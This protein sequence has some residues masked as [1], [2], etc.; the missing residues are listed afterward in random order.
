ML[1]EA[2]NAA[3]ARVRVLTSRAPTARRPLR[4]HAAT[5]A[6]GH[7][8]DLRGGE[9]EPAVVHRRCE[10]DAEKGRRRPPR[11]GPAGC[12][13]SWGRGAAL[14][15]E[16][17]G[18]CSHCP[19]R[20]QPSVGADVRGR[21]HA[22]RGKERGDHHAGPRGGWSGD[23]HATGSALL[24]DTTQQPEP[25]GEHRFHAAEV[26]SVTAQPASVCCSW[27]RYEPWQH[28]HSPPA[29]TTVAT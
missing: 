2:L 6:G 12:G 28:R 8:A 26:G 3:G 18:I 11:A 5:A 14:G 17:A 25:L 9:R 24:N 16:V 10:V 20:R 4:L 7:G 15:G 22:E 29:T 27:N 13:W 1:A 23:R 19:P 21:A